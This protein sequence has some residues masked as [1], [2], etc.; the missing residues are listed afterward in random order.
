[1]KDDPIYLSQELT[2]KASLGVL[3]VGGNFC[4]GILTEKYAKVKQN[5]CT[6]VFQ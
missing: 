6:K 4:T 3:S 5:I 2:W 1:M